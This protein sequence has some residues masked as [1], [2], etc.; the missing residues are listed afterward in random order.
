MSPLALDPEARFE[1]VLATDQDKPDPPAFVFRYLADRDWRAVARVYDHVAELA[2]DGLD[3]MLGGLEDA[4]RIPLVG[5]R[6]M[7]DPATGK[8][9]PYDPR[10]LD[11]VLAPN[12]VNELLRQFIRQS[13][14]GPDEKKGSGSQSPMSSGGSAA[15]ATPPSAAGSSADG[16]AASRNST[17]QPVAGGKGDAP[18]APTGGSS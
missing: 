10:E 13:Q 7:T 14:L 12:E 17:A 8:P 15:T 11:R 2:K 6:G 4:V 3:A 5:W 18:T 9:I 16:P 1:I